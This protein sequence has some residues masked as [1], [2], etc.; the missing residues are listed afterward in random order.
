MI[1]G[2]AGLI[3]E[4][5]AEDIFAERVR[6]TLCGREFVMPVLPMGPEETWKAALD[7]SL[8][9]ALAQIAD[10]NDLGT[11]VEL[12][13]RYPQQ[14][15]DALVAYDRSGVLPPREEIIAGTTKLGILR[16]VLEVRQ[17]ANPLAAIGL[18]MMMA[19]RPDSGS[20]PRSSSPRRRTGGRRATS[21][22]R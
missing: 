3:S 11:A 5:S 12:L 8:D 7:T 21:G 9:P 22:K 15:V 10:T 18:A 1:E 6:V 13:E 19:G 16:A 20:S 2:L 17:A 14:L 4:R